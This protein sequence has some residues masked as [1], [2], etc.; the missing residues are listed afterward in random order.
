MTNKI[1]IISNIDE[2]LEFINLENSEN[3]YLIVFD[4]SDV[5]IGSTETLGSDIWLTK[6]IKK[7]RNIN[8]IHKNMEYA[9]SLIN[10]NT[11][12]SNTYNVVHKLCNSSNVD[13]FILTSRN[14][15]YYSQ[16]IKHIRDAGLA[17]LFIRQNMLNVKKSNDIIIKGGNLEH[18]DNL[19]S[20]NYPKF[21]QVRYIDN[22]CFC[23]N[24]NKGL[25]IEELIGR[26]YTT[27]SKKKYNYILM[28]DDSID[29]INK[30]HNQFMRPSRK[31]IFNDTN[32]YAIH[33]S[34]ME[35][36]K[37]LYND[38]S[39]R[40]DDQKIKYMRN[41][42]A[43]MNGKISL[44]YVLS[45]KVLLIISILWWIAFRFLGISC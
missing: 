17:D 5:L 42:I 38:E 14:V 15:I 25:V 37:R 12:E 30:V 44:N 20:L 11:I 3:R 45:F 24:N 7:G 2:L 6:N 39:L 21:D 29:N 35:I 26:S 31:N 40:I 36:D 34:Y 23:G 1:E 8:I 16:T 28:I 41:G 43:Y 19:Y 32:T 22:I 10:Y 27:N 4:L 9:Y 18:N 33:Y 13:Y